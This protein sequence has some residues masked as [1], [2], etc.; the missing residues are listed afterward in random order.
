[1]HTTS[2]G[3]ASGNTRVSQLVTRSQNG[4]LTAFEQLYR[5]A[6]GRVYALCL[7]LSADR[8][9]A[10][11][12]TQEVFIQ[13]W[14]SISSFRGDSLF[15][16]WLHGVA[17]NVVLA[18][19]RTEERRTARVTVT[20]DP[21][22]EACRQEVASLRALLTAAD[23]LPRSVLPERDLWP[24]IEAQTAAPQAAGLPGAG[25]PPEG[26]Y[27][28]IEPETPKQRPSIPVEDLAPV[29]RG[30]T[31]EVR[32]LRQAIEDLRWAIESSLPRAVRD[33]DQAGGGLRVL[34]SNP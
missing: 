6:V 21:K 14:K 22:C 15:S 17:V 1:M 8:V 12:L 20:D 25:T 28:R 34:R 13:V 5:E 29:V 7:R 11:E 10:E 16:T 24:E 30:L 3:D 26:L 2:E 18:E 33:T 32:E 9:R 31:S 27:N 4:D 19:R 23:A